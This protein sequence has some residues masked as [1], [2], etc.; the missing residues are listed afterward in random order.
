M[1]A[2]RNGCELE[3]GGPSVSKLNRILIAVLLGFAVVGCDSV[4]L[5]IGITPAASGTLDV[6]N[7]T[8]AAWTNARLTAEVVESDNST[9]P[10]AERT[11][12][13]WRPGEKV[14]IPS[15]GNKIRLVVTTGGKTARFTYVNGQLFRLFG[16]KE[17]PVAP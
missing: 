13:S 1:N 4:D 15:C 5:T 16:R 9:T 12:P 2:D 8:S 6:A 17:V 14:S 11:T 10:C 3:T 7:V